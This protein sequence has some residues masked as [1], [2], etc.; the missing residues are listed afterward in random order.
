[1]ALNDDTPILK[2]LEESTPW[3]KVNRK[4]DT[5]V[6]AAEISDLTL[7]KVKVTITI[8]VPKDTTGFSTNN[9]PFGDLITDDSSSGEQIVFHNINGMKDPK[10]W[11]QIINSMREN[12]AN[13]WIHGMV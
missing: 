8:R 11:Y 10:N 7:K 6:E 9:L 3:T 13:I 4:K 2:V 5:K 1:M 12:D